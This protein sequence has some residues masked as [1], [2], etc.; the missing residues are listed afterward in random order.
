MKVRVGFVVLEGSLRNSKD[1]Y[2]RSYGREKV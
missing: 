2:D 1:L